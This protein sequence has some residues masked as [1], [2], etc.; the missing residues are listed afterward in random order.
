MRRRAFITLLGGAAAAW[1]RTAHAQQAD[2]M[3]RL[4]VLIGGSRD[5]P[6]WER[7]TTA[8]REAL[9]KLG[10]IEGGNLRIDLG[11]AAGDPDRAR[12]AAAEL[13]RSAPEVI[14]TSSGFAT[15]AAQQLTRT[16][17]I[18]F[19]GPSLAV[20]ENEARPTGNVTGFP[21]LY[22]SIAGKWVELLKEVDARISR[23]ALIDSPNTLPTATGSSYIRSIEQAAPAL[24]VK[25]IEAPFHSSTELERAI[26]AFAAQ[27]NGGV[28]VLP[29]AATSIRE[30]RDLIRRLAAQYRLPAIHWDNSYPAEGGLMSYGSDFE[31]LHRRAASYVDRI[32]RGAKVSELPVERPTKF[33]LIINLKAAR[34]IGL[35]VPPALLALADE[36]IE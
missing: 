6:G 4:G 22:P 3:R 24:A 15:R 13:L 21:I 35:E 1:P 27:P 19:A 32:L 29:S 23:I 34:A 11:F 18:V 36:V 17:P 31:E 7:Y 2:R 16:I 8:F 14:F 26:D 9:A 5:D 33:E 28:I 12:A 25:A 30:N 10:W 20:G